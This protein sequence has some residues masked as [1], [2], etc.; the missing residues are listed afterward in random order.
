MKAIFSQFQKIMPI[1]D[2]LRQEAIR[3]QR[4]DILETCQKVR[5]F[6]EHQNN[7]HEISHNSLLSIQQELI[8]LKHLHPFINELCALIHIFLSHPLPQEHA[9]AFDELGFHLLSMHLFLDGSRHTEFDVTIDAGTDMTMGLGLRLSD[10]TLHQFFSR[11]LQQSPEDPERI[12]SP[13]FD[14]SASGLAN[15][16]LSGQPALMDFLRAQLMIRFDKASMQRHYAF[17]DSWLTKFHRLFQSQLAQ[18]AQN[19]TIA[20]KR[21]LDAQ[22]MARQTGIH[23]LRGFAMLFDLG[24]HTPHDFSQI[25]DQT[26]EK[27]KMLSLV[28][29]SIAGMNGQSANYWQKRMQTIF[30]GQGLF[31]GREYDE[32]RFLGPEADKRVWNDSTQV[33]SEIFQPTDIPI[34]GHYYLVKPGDRLAQLAR[35]ANPAHPDFRRIVRQNPHISSNHQLIP[36]TSIF[37][38]TS[39]APA[40]QRSDDINAQPVTEGQSHIRLYDRLIGPI[41]PLSAKQVSDLIRKLGNTPIQSLF[42]TTASFYNHHWQIA[43]DKVNFLQIDEQTEDAIESFCASQPEFAEDFEQQPPNFPPP[44]KAEFWAN[45]FAASIRGDL[46]LPGGIQLPLGIQPLQPHRRQWLQM[47]LQRAMLSPKFHSLKIYLSPDGTRA[48]I[49]DDTGNTL[50]CLEQPDFVAI[51]QQ[52][53]RRLQ[54]I[55]HNPLQS[56]MLFTQLWAGDLLKKHAEIIVFPLLNANEFTISEENHETQFLTPM[57]TPVYAIARGT[58]V[59]AGQF[60]HEGNALLI[61]HGNHLY[62]RYAHLSTLNVHTGQEIFA[63][64]MLGRSGVS[65]DVSQPLLGISLECRY[66]PSQNWYS[67]GAQRIL[68]NDVVETLWPKLPNLDIVIHR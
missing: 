46:I 14:D 45:R 2:D 28:N 44:S 8:R 23:S 25:F 58:V 27:Q 41:Q 1:L 55:P 54:E 64:S 24:N 37:I 34:P 33:I 50:I 42:R 62:S 10:G 67:S 20:G 36:G 47:S 31:E 21:L 15:A 7:A 19:S 61:F 40:P 68:F 5:V 53:H 11:I 63:D 13:F 52:P 39:E 16:V 9:Q 30:H 56:A 17:P 38:P 6:F 12:F 49:V 32:R 57:G 18:N 60:P 35:R 51:R 48:D 29:V 26:S 4:W 3:N 66:S 43:C 59:A 65:G 22:S